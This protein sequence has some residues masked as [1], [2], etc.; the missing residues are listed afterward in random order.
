ME[1]LAGLVYVRHGRIGSKSEGP[2]YVLQTHKDEVELKLNERHPW[3]LDYELEFYCRKMVVV[4]GEQ[5]GD[6]T[7]Q[8][9][10]IRV[11]AE[12]LIPQPKAG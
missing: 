6:Q 11:I 8:V 3:E 2:D 1:K 7:I 10:S 12:T 5:V 9:T 4:E